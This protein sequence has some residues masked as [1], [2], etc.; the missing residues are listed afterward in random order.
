MSK[1]AQYILLASLIVFFIAA[2][3]LIKVTENPA[4][5]YWDEAAIAYNAFGIAE[6]NRD[7]WGNKLPISFRSFGDYKAP[8]LIYVLSVPYKIFGLH[9]DWLR[10]LAAI[11][12]TGNVLLTFLLFKKIIPKATLLTQIFFIGFAATTPWYFHFSRFGNEASLALFCILAG[13]YFF[14][15]AEKKPLFYIISSL[16]LCSSLYAYHS[17]KFFTPILIVILLGH[18]LTSLKKQLKFVIPSFLLGFV[19]LIPLGLDTLT[20]SGFERGKSLIVFENNSLA[21]ALVIAQKALANTLSFL[22]LDFWV[23]GK[24]SIG[25]RHGLPGF[26]V[27]LRSELLLTFIGLCLVLFNKKYTR[28]RW[29]GLLTLIGLL[30]SILSNDAPHAIRAMMAAPWL[31]L[32]AGI[33]LYFFSQLKLS[34]SKQNMLMLII[35]GALLI[36]SGLYLVTYFKKYSLISAPHFQYGYKQAFEYINEHKYEA[37]T[38]IFTDKLGQPYIYSLFFRGITPEEYKFGALANYEFHEIKWPDDRRRRMYVATP[39]EISPTDPAVVKVISYPYS[40][41]PAL[42]I[43]LN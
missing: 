29:L 15:K 39:E 16:F 40:S 25:P 11:L 34:K 41:E 42:V 43:A 18:H 38:F 8:L 21:S 7:E 12:G 36:E 33:A 4:G 3:R 30:P 27:L 28:S 26:G 37:D 35:S 20:G 5:L 23:N 32:L 13:T 1:K 6:W 10:Y 19:L 9:I 2:I 24:D 17:A 31:L 22:S 14:L